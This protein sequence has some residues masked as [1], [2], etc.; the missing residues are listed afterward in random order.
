MYT[1]IT[2]PCIRRARNIYKAVTRPC[3]GR[4]RPCRRPLCGRVR[5][6]YVYTTRVHHCVR[7][8]CTDVFGRVHGAYTAPYMGRIHRHVLAVHTTRIR[9]R[10]RAHVYKSRVHGRAR[11][12]YMV[13]NGS[14]HGQCTRPKTAVNTTRILPCARGDMARTWP[15]AR[16]VTR[17]CTAV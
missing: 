5:A 11:V 1:D 7:A 6:V 15:Y 3:T 10:T 16:H 2:P 8:V 14:A 4:P 9:P 13:E 12:I 17:P